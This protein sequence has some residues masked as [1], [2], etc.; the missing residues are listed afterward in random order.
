MNARAGLALIV[1]GSLLSL[2]TVIVLWRRVPGVVA[3]VLSAASGAIV[4]A[5][6]LLVQQDPGSGDWALTLVVLG[7]LTP[8]HARLVFGLP[9]RSP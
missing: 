5:G 1:L 2:L 3:L 4:G 6:A 7:V 8:V 9:G